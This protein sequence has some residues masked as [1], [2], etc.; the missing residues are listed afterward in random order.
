MDSLKHLLREFSV[1]LLLS[2]ERMDAK[3][4]TQSQKFFLS[5]PF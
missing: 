5:K 4:L 3:H 2:F 1:L